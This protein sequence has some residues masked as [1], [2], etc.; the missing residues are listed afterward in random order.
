MRYEFRLSHGVRDPGR[1]TFF[2][3]NYIYLFVEVYNASLRITHHM[4]AKN[5][6]KNQAG[7]FL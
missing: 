3:D 1:N 4:I 6:N 7:K 2:F 5:R